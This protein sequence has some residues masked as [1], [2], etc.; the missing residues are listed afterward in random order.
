MN[1]FSLLS[2]ESATRLMTTFGHCLWEGLVIAVVSAV[3]AR[4][5]CG[6]NARLRYSVHLAALVLIV[7]SLPVTYLLV[8]TAPGPLGAER[9][10]KFRQP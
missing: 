1:I 6:R 8:G 5:L 4:L 3:V 9:C 2:S 7:A 10:L